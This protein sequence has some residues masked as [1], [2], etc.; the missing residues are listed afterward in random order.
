MRD[1][2]LVESWKK[3]CIWL[4]NN[5]QVTGTK[6]NRLGESYNHSLYLAGL[7]KIEKL[8]DEMRRRSIKYGN[9]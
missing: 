3:G 1:G 4:T 6:K 5:E 2:E 7:K 9:N 8:E